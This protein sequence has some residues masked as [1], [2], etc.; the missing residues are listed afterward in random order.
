[1]TVNEVINAI[2]EVMCDKHADRLALPASKQ[3]I[4]AYGP[5][6]AVRKVNSRYKL[7]MKVQEGPNDFFW[8]YL[9]TFPDRNDVLRGVYHSICGRFATSN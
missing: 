9:P 3:V 2:C 8:V 1:M 5:V 6:T 7:E 4:S